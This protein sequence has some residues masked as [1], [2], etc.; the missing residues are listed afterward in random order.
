MSSPGASARQSGALQLQFLAFCSWAKCLRERPRSGNFSRRSICLWVS[1]LDRLG[2]CFSGGPTIRTEAGGL[3]PLQISSKAP[4][5]EK[6]KIN[7][8]DPQHMLVDGPGHFWQK[9]RNRSL[10]EQL[11]FPK[12]QHSYY[13]RQATIC[14]RMATN[15]RQRGSL[16]LPALGE[17]SKEHKKQFYI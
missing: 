12:R 5:S 13:K 3:N 16:A 17:Y 10:P 8:S 2:G 11:L 6:H 4:P 1:N 15:K 14:H 7:R 9:S